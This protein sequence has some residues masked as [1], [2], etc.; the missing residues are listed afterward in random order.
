MRGGIGT[1]RKG[2]DPGTSQPP[3]LRTKRKHQ[4]SVSGRDEKSKVFKKESHCVG[5]CSWAREKD[6]RLRRRLLGKH[7]QPRQEDLSS[8]PAS[9]YKLCL[10]ILGA[11]VNQTLEGQSQ[12]G[13]IW[14]LPDPWC[15]RA[16]AC[17]YTYA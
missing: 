5:V 9:T 2:L 13:D 12:G 6:E 8:V 10:C 14:M 3:E 15:P 7:L 11:F 1:G 17:K 16:C 4:R